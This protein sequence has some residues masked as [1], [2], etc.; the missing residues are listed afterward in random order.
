MSTQQSPCD[1]TSK[2]SAECVGM[3][4][5]TTG[6]LFA[7]TGNLTV[8]R[9]RVYV[10]TVIDWA[11]LVGVVVG[12]VA[13]TVGVSLLLIRRPRGALAATVRVW[14]LYRRQWVRVLHELGLTETQ[15]DQVHVPRL[16]SV[17]RQSGS[18]VLTVR[19]LPGQAAFQW[20]ERSAALAD[21]FDASSAMVSFGLHRHR[22]VV[23]T[24]NRTHTPRNSG[25]T[26]ALEQRKPDPLLASLELGQQKQHEK[27]ESR[28][29]IRAS[30]VQLRLAWARVQRITDNGNE[31]LAAGRPRL[32]LR[33]EMRWATWATG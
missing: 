14:W 9:I 29:V 11:P 6:A 21:E 12:S 3:L 20:H 10:Q 5:L 28:L 2:D 31:V 27:Q 8:N 19:M 15:G 16:M 7:W 13:L 23:I 24:I 32:G 1:W 26:L 22:D 18:D 30:G 17:V 25:P 4:A 33:G